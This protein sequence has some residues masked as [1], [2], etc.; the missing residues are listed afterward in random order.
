MIAVVI[1][2]TTSE[3][4][5]YRYL[6]FLDVGLKITGSVVVLTCC[7][8]NCQSQWDIL[9]VMKTT[10]MAADTIC[11]SHAVLFIG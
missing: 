8:G 4:V 1:I 7:K 5:R 2:I 10:C 9:C 11:C 3:I 6:L